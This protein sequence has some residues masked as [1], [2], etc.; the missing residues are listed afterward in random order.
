EGRAAHRARARALEVAGRARPAPRARVT[1]AEAVVDDAVA[2][3]V[4]SVAALLVVLVAGPADV[5][6]AVHARLGRAL[7]APRPALADAVTKLPDRDVLV[8][9]AV[10]VVVLSVALLGHRHVLGAAR[11]GRAARGR[12]AGALEVPLR[13]L[14]GPLA[15]GADEEPVVGDAVA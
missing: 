3:V 8:G 14:A 7:D 9:G 15:R 6:R 10:T 1:D 13:A 11:V 5:R 4:L 12:G 2:V